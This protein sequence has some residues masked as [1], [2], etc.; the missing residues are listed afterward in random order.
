MILQSFEA[1]FV[2]GQPGRHHPTWAACCQELRRGQSAR[3][4]QVTNTT[5]RSS[6]TKAFN[7]EITKE[8]NINIFGS[9]RVKIRRFS[10]RNLRVTSRDPPEPHIRQPRP[11]CDD[12]QT[13]AGFFTLKRSEIRYHLICVGSTWVKHIIIKCQGVLITVLRRRPWFHRGNVKASWQR[14]RSASLNTSR[15]E[16]KM[17]ASKKYYFT[18]WDMLTHW[19]LYLNHTAGP[20]KKVK[21]WHGSSPYSRVLFLQTEPKSPDAAPQRCEKGRTR[22]PDTSFKIKYRG[23]APH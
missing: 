4:F 15:S 7:V 11:A 2:P 5:R 12:E 16:N 1:S 10:G 20:Q 21:W 22:L 8:E 19:R 9:F 13:E 23:S 17:A 14:H 18:Y 3:G 6:N